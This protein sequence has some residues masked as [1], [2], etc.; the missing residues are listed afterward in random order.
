[1]SVTLPVGHATRLSEMVSPH[2][3]RI[4]DTIAAGHASNQLK[5]SIESDITVLETALLQLRTSRNTCLPLLRLPLETL[6]EVIEILASIWPAVVGYA[7]EGPLL[8]HV[9]FMEGRNYKT[10]PSLRLGWILLAHVCRKL[11]AAVLARNDLWASNICSIT[12]SPTDLASYYGNAPLHIDV[13]VNLLKSIPRLRRTEIDAVKHLL[14]SSRAIILEEHVEGS[15]DTLFANLDPGFFS[16]LQFPHL[17]HLSLDLGY[18]PSGEDGENEAI[19]SEIF[20]L[21]EMMAPNLRS[22]HLK[23]YMISFDPSTLTDLKLQLAEPYSAILSTRRFLTILR[24]SVNLRSLDIASCIPRLNSH[25]AESDKVPLPSLERLRLRGKIRRCHDLLTH[26]T[27]PRS[28]RYDVEFHYKQID[29]PGAF[30]YLNFSLPH[31]THLDTS[32]VTGMALEERDKVE[33]ALYTPKSS[34]ASV[35]KAPFDLFA[36]GFCRHHDLSFGGDSREHREPCLEVL[37]AHA[38]TFTNMSAIGTLQ[39]AFG[40]TYGNDVWI[41]CLSL[42]PNLVTLSLDGP[43]RMSALFAMKATNLDDSD[44]AQT[45]ET[46]IVLPRL[47]FLW[48]SA[49]DVRKPRNDEEAQQGGP[50]RQQFLHI[51]SSRR[52]AGAPL[53]RLRIDKL[54]VPDYAEAK[55]V[56]LPRMETLVPHVEVELLERDPATEYAEEEDSEEL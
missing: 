35:T 22:L 2:I 8:E 51:L 19:T 48:I 27:L 4:D 36:D 32:L 5:Q 20:E 44:S 43:G 15:N 26:L 38:Q 7:R 3:Q 10:C 6:G 34:P 18:L 16:K 39:I 30:E 17:Q 37:L 47:S 33:I 14:R 45:D 52:R 24:R 41:A 56:L 29:F 50:D 28:T 13:R 11:R 12:R 49:L 25:L 53:D 55:K 21:P 40:N 46:P 31:F 42:F 1:M 54:L 23:N 9:A